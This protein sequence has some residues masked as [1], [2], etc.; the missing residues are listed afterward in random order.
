MNGLLL[1]FN[2]YY[3]PASM[4]QSTIVVYNVT[5]GDIGPY[6]MQIGDLPANIYYDVSVSIVNNIGE[7]MKSA[8][9]RTKT[10]PRGKYIT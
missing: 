4:A 9:K 5:L 8:A 7:G 2:I 6:A 10:F 3:T 1:A